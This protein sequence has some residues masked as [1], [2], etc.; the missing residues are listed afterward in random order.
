[1]D[2]DSVHLHLEHRIVRRLLGRFTAQGFVRHD[3]AR[4]CLAQSADAI[5]RVI[6]LG[7][8]SLYGPGAVRLHEAIVHVTARWV[9]T[10]RRA[11][12]L[13]PYGR[14]AETRTLTLLEDA[15]LAK[16]AKP[17]GE[18]IVRRLRDAATRDVRE[19]M[20]HLEARG[21]ELAEEAAEQLAKRGDHEAQAMREILETQKRRVA[22]T[23]ER[24]RDPQMTLD[25]DDAALRQLDANRRHWDRRLAAIDRELASEP[26]RIRELYQV[27]AQRIEPVGL[28]YLWPLSG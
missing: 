17:V 15:L 28:V 10:A 14:E 13:A 24:Y 27:K 18:P 20:P 6:L 12:A 5:P 16:H 7:R 9:E 8:L 26:G 22:E 19:L 11:A 23:A 21:G 2:G 25:F 3:L 1:M 4:A